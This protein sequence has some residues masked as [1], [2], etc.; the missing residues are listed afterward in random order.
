MKTYCKGL[1]VSDTTKIENSI[2]G[3][4]RNKFKKNSTIRFISCYTDQS[5]ECVK[6]NFQ[7][8]KSFWKDTIK[9]LGQ[10]MAENISNRTIKEHILLKSHGYPVIRYTKITDKGS[11]KVRILGLETVLFRL[12]EAVAGDAAKPLWNA[13]FGTYQVASIKGRGQSLG[14][15]AVKKWLSSDADGT[16]YMSQCDIKQ[17]YPSISHEKLK[18]YLQRDLHKSSEL[19]YMFMTFI[20]LYEM[21]PNPELEDATRSILI[22]SPISKDLCNYYLSYAYHY[23][24]ERLVKTSTR[25]GK[26]TAK[27]L[28]SHVIFYA[29]DIVLF[30]GNK[31]D[32]HLAQRMLIKY[33]KEALDLEIKA[34]WV[35]IK[36][37]FEDRNGKTKGSI[38]DY[39]GFR[40]HGGVA[41]TKEYLVTKV[42]HRKTW[43]TIRKRIFLISRRK[44]KQLSDKL[45]KKERVNLKFA[46]SVVSQYGWFKNTNM[47]RYRK[48]YKVDQIIKIARRIISDYA[49]GK[50]YNSEKYYKMW[51]KNYA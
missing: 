41:S 20:E 7:P 35:I 12:S 10:E 19:L 40:F 49:K 44:R 23:A 16:K 8:G 33:M 2:D 14:K 30:S 46:Q 13:K 3:Y 27:R 15:K 22:G 45:R 17:C 31:R 47:L 43:I 51:R 21:F 25:R 48:K 5:R 42:R 1:I 32:L 34:S 38:L 6:E 28:I 50:L 24:S 26:T 36:A 29:D 11:G 37:M 9:A 18:A 39:M 4:F